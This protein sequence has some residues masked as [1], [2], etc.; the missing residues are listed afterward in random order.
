MREKGYF[1]S[2]QNLFTGNNE[3]C[4][5]GEK[6]IKTMGNIPTKTFS[7]FYSDKVTYSNLLVPHRI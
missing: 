7:Y 5:A 6:Y 2:L 3:F 1:I 4:S